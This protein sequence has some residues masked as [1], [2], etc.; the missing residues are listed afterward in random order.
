M[1]WWKGTLCLLVLLL[2][3]YSF[4]LIGA[5]EYKLFVGS[6]NKQA[7]EKEVEEVRTCITKIFFFSH[8]FFL[9][10]ISSFA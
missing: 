7:T 6:L 3:F 4:L 10:G 2:I 9:I 8:V 1:S 5:V